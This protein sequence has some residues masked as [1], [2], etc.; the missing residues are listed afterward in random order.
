MA[1]ILPFATKAS[2]APPDAAARQQALD[3]RQSFIVEA[4]AGSGKTGLL[5]Q[6]LLK[7]LTSVEQPEQVLAITFTTKATAEMRDRVLDQLVAVSQTEPS[8]VKPG[9]PSTAASPQWMGDDNRP[10]PEA[11]FQATTESLARAVLARDRQLGWDLLDHPHR[12]NIRTIDSVCAEIAR[13][14][15]VLSGSGGRLTPANDAEPLH[16]E[17]ARSTL[18]LLGSGDAEL[19][20]A[21]RDLLLHR[22]GNLAECESLIANMLSLRDQWGDLIPLSGPQLNEAWLDANVLPR[23]ELALAEAVRAGLIQLEQLFPAEQLAELTSLATEFAQAASYNP[24]SPSPVALCADRSTPPEAHANHL[25]HWLALMH[26]LLTKNGEW[27]KERGITGKNLNFDYDRKHRNHARLVAVLNSLNGRDDLLRA[28]AKVR[29]LPP[30]YYPEDQW[31][32]AKILF[33]VLSR[34][35]IELQ[36]VFASRNQCDFTELSLLARHALDADSGPEDLAA[37]LGARLQHLLVDEMQDTSTGQYELIERLTASWDGYSQT[38][39]LVGDPRQS[40]YLFRQARVERFIHSMRTQQLGDLLLTRLRLT[41][42]F[43]SQSTL[44]E[45][46][47]QNFNLIFPK[48]AELPYTPADATLPT[49]PHARA[50]VW[51]ANPISTTPDNATAVLSAAE[52]K[53]QQRQ[54]DASEICRIAREWME[55]PLPP[56]RTKPWE[57]AVLVAGRS[58][59]TEI[60]AALQQQNALDRVPFRAVEIEALDQRQE[61]LDLSALTRALLHPA[62]RVAV[63]AVLRAP[64]CGLSLA[65]LHTLTGSDDSA[66]KNYSI[67]RLMDERGHLLPDETLWRL[68]RVWQ[69]LSNASAQRSRLGLTQ[70]VERAWRSLGGDTWLSNTQADN[71]HLFFSLLDDIQLELELNPSTGLLDTALLQRRLQKLFAEPESIPAGTPFV[72]LL[73]IHKAK[74][75]EWDVV[76]IPSLERGPGRN[77]TRLLTWAEINAPETADLLEDP[78]DDRAAHIMLAPIAG[79]GEESKALNRW[80][81]GIQSAREAA[82]RKRLFYVA[83]TRARE[84]LHLFAAPQ[85]SSKGEI[86]PQFNCLLKAAWSAADLHFATT[87]TPSAGVD[88]EAA[89]PSL[90]PTS[91]T[92]PSATPRAESSTD[93]PLVLDLAAA[94]TPPLA[95]K[96]QPQATVERLPTGFDP[97]ARF[98]AARSYRLPYGD[99]DSFTASS[100]NQFLRPEGSFAAR[101]FGNVVHAVLEIFASRIVN[102]DSPEALLAGLPSLLSAMLRADG[103]PQAAVSRLAREAYSALEATLRDRDGLWL[104]S[105]HTGAASELALTALSAPESSSSSDTSGA[106]ARAISIRIDRLFYAGSEPH[107]AGEDFLWII[108]YKTTAPHSSV[109]L[110]EFLAHQRETYAP[111]LENY[112]RILTRSQPTPTKVRLALYFP[113]LS[114]LDWWELP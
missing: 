9:T 32:V 79:R 93:E 49:S 83:C 14:L 29:A 110:D 23:L 69:V 67:Q 112:S 57:I 63:L 54:R 70:L 75:L 51:H 19:D 102:G 72:E 86:V 48:D 90:A 3:I 44:V 10:E 12:L 97:A 26:I 98:A 36:L 91:L 88:Q 78:E 18:L 16:R 34:A 60:V 58:H 55:K 109:G 1:D 17:A 113:L 68:Q 38:V 5:I 53:Q 114:R 111:Q 47:N 7:L 61:I 106:S 95:A 15:P 4:P 81:N 46:F 24:E 40:I 74:G 94:A 103:L 39:F 30:T 100:Q 43:R 37:A 99:A 42:N 96:V 76:L 107:A 92:M 64:W 22:D 71:A 62:D 82:E 73:T 35:L 27:R 77:P 84:E 33:R 11:D 21:L 87:S 6:R 52:L 20:S 59:L 28:F 101:S 45:E 13:A 104:L 85:I 31:A 105:P 89:A 65:D 66:L 56:G 41:A 108:D 50:T 25:D 2:A 80:L 8:E